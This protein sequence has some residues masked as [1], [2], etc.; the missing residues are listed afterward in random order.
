M[1]ALRTALSY[2]EALKAACGHP[3]DCGL[4]G[5]VGPQPRVR[6]LRQDLGGGKAWLVQERGEQAEVV[7]A[8]PLRALMRA[9]S[10]PEGA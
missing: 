2:Q 5:G 8:Q 10:V 7:G 6:F 3:I 9:E 1:A 4:G